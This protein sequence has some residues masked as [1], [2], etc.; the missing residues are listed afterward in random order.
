[1]PRVAALAVLVCLLTSGLSAQ[2]LENLQIHGFVT[3]GFLFSTQNNY[4]T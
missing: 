1:M 2:D 4:L 3:Q